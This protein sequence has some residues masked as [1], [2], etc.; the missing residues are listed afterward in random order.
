MGGGNASFVAA[1]K[2][3]VKPRTP[4]TPSPRKGPGELR[5][6]VARE[7][8]ALID[9]IVQLR[10]HSSRSEF[11]RAAI[12]DRFLTQAKALSTRSTE[13]RSITG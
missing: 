12:R 10:L 3:S 7:H 13:H 6:L 1:R 5:V 11:V 9:A 4:R 2:R 8:L